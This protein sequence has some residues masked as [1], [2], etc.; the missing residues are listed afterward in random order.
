MDS[1]EPIMTKDGM[2]WVSGEEAEKIRQG[3][4]NLD[5]P[6][7]PDEEEATLQAALRQVFGD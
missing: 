5:Q 3:Q 2:I 7:S 6:L 1:R 4:I